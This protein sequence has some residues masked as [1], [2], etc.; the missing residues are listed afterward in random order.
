[1]PV[2]HAKMG[3]RHRVVGVEDGKPFLEDG[4]PVDGG[5]FKT[6]EEALI[7]VKKINKLYY[8]GDKKKPDPD[9]DS[10]KRSILFQID[11]GVGGPRPD[12]DV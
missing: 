5:G 2:K 10:P 11:L 12:A 3:G 6:P 4:Q 1:M 7:L 8:D 9:R